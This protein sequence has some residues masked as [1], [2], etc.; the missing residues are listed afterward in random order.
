VSRP[1]VIVVG[2]GAVGSAALYQ[3]ARRGVRALGID[4]FQPPH[5]HGSSHGGTR[6]TRLAIGEGAP[7]VQFVRRA[8]QTWR[9]LEEAAECSLLCSVGGLIFGST[10]TC[11]AAHG[12]GDFLETTIEVAKK[13]GIAHEVLA[14]DALR[15]RFPQFRWRGD[16]RGYFEPEAGFVRPE[17]CIAAQLKSAERLGVEIVTGERVLEWRPS[18]AGI[19]VIAERQRYEA[20]RLILTAGSWLPGWLPALRERGGVYRQVQFWFEPDG[21]REIFAPDRMPVFIRVAEKQEEMFYGFPASE[22]LGGRVKIAGEQFNRETSPDD[23]QREVP[24]GEAAAM[25]ALAAPHLRITSHC[26]HAVACKYTM[27][28][29]F[30]FVI[31]RHPESE[32]VFFASAC[33]GH[34]FKHSAGV[35]EALAELAVNG[36]TQ[37]DL[38]EFS[39]EKLLARSRFEP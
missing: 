19:E 32:R 14:A 34:G 2:L 28:P 23:F 31:D 16:E 3:L 30:K 21:P 9:E 8:H 29:D 22:D 6:I 36:T 17:E 1:E 4:R 7:Y 15:D 10:A 35:G 11:G 5:D 24:P 20:D 39:L 37:F 18:G 13:H 38:S 27:M 26:V 25:H 33:S 12:R